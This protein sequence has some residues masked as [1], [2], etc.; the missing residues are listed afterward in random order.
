MK[1]SQNHKSSNVGLLWDFI[2]LNYHMENLFPYIMFKLPI[3]WI[4]FF[5]IVFMSIML[6]VQITSY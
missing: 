6:I 5:Q 1:T 2:N 3:T 4:I